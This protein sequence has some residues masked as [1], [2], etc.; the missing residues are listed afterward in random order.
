[1][2][3]KTDYMNQ[4]SRRCAVCCLVLGSAWFLKAIS[5]RLINSLP[6]T[7]NVVGDVP[8]QH[9]CSK[10]TSLNA[11][12]LV[13]KLINTLISYLTYTSLSGIT[14]LPFIWPF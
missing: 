3:I 9:Q 1:M 5:L 11:P 2:L 12:K 6:T 7:V 13:T 4:P 14:S 10:E 8:L